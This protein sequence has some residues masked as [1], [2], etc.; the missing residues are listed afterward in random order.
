MSLSIRMYAWSTD[1]LHQT[2]CQKLGANVPYIPHHMKSLMRSSVCNVTYKVYAV[3]YI[4]YKH[5]NWP[6]NLT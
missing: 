3:V 2:I 5:N 4:V 6:E 1:P